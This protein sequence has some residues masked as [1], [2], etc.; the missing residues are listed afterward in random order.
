MNEARD[1]LRKA[2]VLSANSNLN[3][4]NI[5]KILWFL[6]PAEMQIGKFPTA[7]ILDQH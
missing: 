7:E 6:I 1:F 3:V 5:R 4:V 2:Y